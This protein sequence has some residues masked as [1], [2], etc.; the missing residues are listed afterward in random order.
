MELTNKNQPYSAV[1]KNET[2]QDNEYDLENQFLPTGMTSICACKGLC[3]GFFIL[4][5]GLCIGLFTIL[6]N[7]M[8]SDSGT[9]S[10]QF[11]SSI[12]IIAS[13]LF[14]AGGVC[15]FF[16]QKFKWLLPG[17]ITQTVAFLPIPGVDF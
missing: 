4:M 10:A 6:P 12:G 3:K 15:G 14:M 16:H 5:L 17:L 13:F 7:A 8:L 11:H 9:Q 1:A 2:S